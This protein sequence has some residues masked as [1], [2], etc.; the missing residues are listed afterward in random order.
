M[1]SRVALALAALLFAG[2]AVARVLS[3]PQSHLLGWSGVMRGEYESWAW[4]DW[5]IPREAAYRVADA[6]GWLHAVP[7]LLRAPHEMGIGNWL[8]AW[9][10]AI[11]CKA[12]LGPVGGHNLHVLLVLLTNF[13]AAWLAVRAAQTTPDDGAAIVGALAIA[14]NPITLWDIAESRFAEGW[15]A[16]L[17][18]YFACIVRPQA[19]LRWMLLAAAALALCALTWLFAP[20]LLL[21]LGVLACLHDKRTLLHLPLGAIIALLFLWPVVAR[22][23]TLVALGTPFP[24]LSGLTLPPI[25]TLG[26]PGPGLI[27]AYSVDASRPLQPVDGPALP[28]PWLLAAAVGAAMAWRSAGEVNRPGLT[29]AHV[30]PTRLTSGA[31]LVGRLGRLGRAAY[32]TRARRF[33]S[34]LARPYS[35]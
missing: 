16:P 31:A 15:L 7:S 34:S 13:G 20:L 4:L 2:A 25:G 28:W 18:L 1:N 19:T 26:P 27:V 10:F 14:A 35:S 5:W 33:S 3:D 17:L 30:R 23:T 6:G 32:L 9:L 11:P 24:P 29:S 8:D 12:L 22:P 21:P